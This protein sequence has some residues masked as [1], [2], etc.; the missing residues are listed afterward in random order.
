MQRHRKETPAGSSAPPVAVCYQGGGPWWQWGLEW[1]PTA[2][3]TSPHIAGPERTRVPYPSL[4][5]AG[6]EPGPRWTRVRCGQGCVSLGRFRGRIRPPTVPIPRTVAQG[7]LAHSCPWDVLCPSQ[8]RYMPKPGQVHAH[9][10]RLRPCPPPQPPPRVSDHTP[11]LAL[12]SVS[13]HAPTVTTPCLRSA[14][15]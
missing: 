3:A 10:C 9:T 13:D 1:Y 4:L 7:C 5:D 15:Q 6:Q 12:T 11:P 2:A 14:R 8:D